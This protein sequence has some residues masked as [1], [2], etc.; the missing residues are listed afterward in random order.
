M[1]EQS[2][3]SRRFHFVIDAF[4]CDVSLI[5]NK[6]L[7]VELLL[8]VTKL[9]DMKVLKG[10]EIAEG[11]PENPGLSA[12]AIIDFSHISIHTFTNSKEFCLDIFSCKTFDYKKLEKYI[13]R[14]FALKN[15][16]MY[17]S[18]VRYNQFNIERDD[19][20]CSVQDYLDEYY[21]RLSKE[22]IEILDWYHDTY[23]QISEKD[24]LLD[25]G[26]Y[27][28]VY[29]LCSAASKVKKIT[30][31]NKSQKNLDVFK[32]HVKSGFGYWDK[33][34]EYSLGAEGGKNVSAQEISSRKKEVANKV[35]KCILADIS[36]KFIRLV[37]KFDIVQSDFSLEGSTD[38]ISEYKR[39]LKNVYSYLK[40]GGIFLMVAIEGAVVYKV[41]KKYFPAIYLDKELLE[42][43]LSEA[44]F[45]IKEMKKVHS[46]NPDSSKYHGFLFVKAVKINKML[47]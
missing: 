36:K 1:N 26:D 9:L 15:K 24:S 2:F 30:Y 20:I 6:L 43:Y 17:K 29:Q 16:Q 28:T 19:R 32:E 33:F 44:G 39:M 23:S 5:S 21:S 41:G 7:L 8:E 11:I 25:V 46:D 45:E 10:P 37:N 27:P 31:I 12:F 42:K 14:T 34:I 18:I 4:D 35:D 13:K 38:D 47:N 22:N 40:P 3:T